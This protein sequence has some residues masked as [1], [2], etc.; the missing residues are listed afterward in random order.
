MKLLER[1]RAQP[2]WRSDD[3]AVRVAAVRDLPE[4]DR[5]VLLEIARSDPDPGVRRAAVE[6]MPDL[7]ALVAFLRDAGEAADAQD[8][9]RVEAVAA[10]RDTLIE[11]RDA[12]TAVAA[13]DVLPAERDLAA[14][15]RA[16]ELEPV[17]RAALERL[18][19]GKMLGGVARR[20]SRVEIAL[21]AVGRVTDR[22]ELFAVA[23]RADDKAPAL[24]ACER[25]VDGGELDDAA[26]ET[27][28][29]QARHK[30][31]ARRGRGKRAAA[32]EYRAG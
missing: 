10:V 26:L 21:D 6:R 16:A 2:A 30:G 28:S 11:A 25:L 24:A 23:V 22:D 8:E 20:A 15:A 32:S 31:V 13:L 7:A 4:D 3:P 27:M 5:N 14:V 12:A 19:S 17:A 18:S 9:A 29:R 1:L